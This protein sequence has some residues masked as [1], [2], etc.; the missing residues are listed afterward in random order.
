[1]EGC[2]TILYHN[3]VKCI[4]DE[5]IALSLQMSR[6]RVYLVFPYIKFSNFPETEYRLSQA[7]YIL[8]G[9]R[10]RRVGSGYKKYWTGRSLPGLQFD[11]DREIIFKVN[12]SNSPL[13]GFIS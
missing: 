6:I 5:V 2:I 1:M 12:T 7:N 11:E 13:S 3:T 8:P 10:D 4:D 9:L